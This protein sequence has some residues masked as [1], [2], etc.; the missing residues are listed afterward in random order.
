MN[1]IKLV[2]ES[3]RRSLAHFSEDGA[4]I[5]NTGEF[6]GRS[7]QLRF[8]ARR[9]EIEQDVDWGKVNQPLDPELADQVFS[10][11]EKKLN[12][13]ENFSTSG[14]VG[15]FPIQ[16][17]SFSPW[18]TVFADNMF[19]HQRID[20]L[21]AEIGEENPIQVFH[22]PYG[23]VSDLDLDVEN[24]AIVLLDFVQRK[25]AVIGTAYAGEIKKGAFTLC[26][27]LLPKYGILPMH[28]SANCLTDGKESCVLFGLSGTGKT[29]LSTSADR[30]MIG[31]DE[32]IWSGGGLSNIEG[33]CYAKLIKLDPSKE[34]EIYRAA[35][36]FGSILEN[37]EWDTETR[38]VDFDSDARTENTRGSYS[39]EALDNVFNQ[40]NFGDHPKNIVFLVADAFGA[41]PA[42]ARLN[43]DQ[44]KYHFLSG[45]TA[46]VAG[47]EIGV[48]EPQAVF[49]A[50][51]GA[52]FMPRPP[53]AYA[54]LLAKKAEA[55]GTNVWLLN[56]GWTNGG[57]GKGDRFP[58]KVS[59]QLLRSI[60][61]GELA[62]EATRTHEVFGFEVPKGCPSL[63]DQWLDVPKGAQVEAL[64]E[65]FKG[66][67]PNHASGIR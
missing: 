50:C 14:Y 19:R 7:P 3:V 15:C 5:V 32:I 1:K 28:A 41:M 44:A 26:N 58:I 54:E 46:K 67:L 11:L 35:N 21:A 38:T 45:Y 42:V 43:S 56:T 40:Q 66:N 48:T 24:D 36:R 57:Y 63:E 37:V 22:D 27:F 31:D 25:I 6:T 39:L 9:P 23:K 60:Q 62:K 4:L 53:M 18:H 49:S 47:T 51:F 59:R 55:H 8:I 17:L 30:S 2:E 13:K 16:V 33:G 29:T 52:P 64:A 10:R 34:P 12:S 61:S 65:R 20:Q